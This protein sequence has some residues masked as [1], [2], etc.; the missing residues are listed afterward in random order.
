MNATTHAETQALDTVKLQ[1]LMGRTLVDSSG[2]MQA[3]L[4]VIGDRLGLYRSLAEHGPMTAA[5]LAER[6][7]TTERYVQEW[8][9]ANA[10]S[11]Y[12][13]Y[14][15]HTGRYRMT[16]EQVAVFA[17][18]PS[19]AFMVG[20]FEV[21][22]AA[23][24]VVDRLEAAFKS[25]EGIGWHEHHHQVFHGCER[26]FRSG[27]IAHLVQEWIP[28]LDGMQARLQR[29]AQVADVGCG[30]GASTILLA[31][32]F[33]NSQFIGYDAHAPSLEV[34]RKRAA[35]AGVADRVWFE[36]ATAQTYPGRDFDLVMVFDALHDM[37]DP[38]GASAH[39][40]TTL[41]EDGLWMIVEPNASDRVEDNL[42]PIGRAFYA[43][44]TLMCTPCAL[45]QGH[46]ALGAQAGEER[47]RAVIRAG[48]FAE[49]KRVAQTPF[50][51]I[52][53]ARA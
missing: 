49:V 48:G 6:T 52:L 51:I 43:A 14:L 17:A 53:Q 8:L 15:P 38:V 18:E 16:P 28:A 24:R 44:S 45:Q 5:E 2:A 29:G 22:L 19:P 46:M 50:N 47:L 9:N 42:N 30:H 3:G 32:A 41:A 20:G 37:G 11:Q 23:V 4:V 35:Q 7:Q 31:Q 33:P 12:I 25:G 10:A 21:A 1:Q 26:F 39:V 36:Q 40:L 34:A 27:Y 13:D